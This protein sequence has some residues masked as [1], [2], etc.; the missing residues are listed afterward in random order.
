MI[1]INPFFNDWDTPYCIPPFEEI[2]PEHFEPAFLEAFE[3]HNADI[4]R[5]VEDKSPPTFENTILQLEQAGRMLE[6]VTAVYNCFNQTRATDEQR[7]VEAKIAPLIADH[8]NNIYQNYDLYLRVK[9]VNEKR[10]SL[11]IQKQ[12]ALDVYLQLFKNSGVDLAQ[13]Q[14]TKISEIDSTLSELYAQFNQNVANDEENF[15]LPLYNFN[16]QA[17]LGKEYLANA[18]K[19]GRLRGYDFPVATLGIGSTAY[20]LKHAK[21]RHLRKL[22]Y[23][24]SKARGSGANKN[25]NSG[26]M[27]KIAELRAQRA[28]VLGYETYAEYAHAQNMAENPQMVNDMLSSVWNMALPQMEIDYEGIFELA[29]KDGIRKLEP[30]DWDYYATQYAE[31]VFSLDHALISEYLVLDNCLDAAFYAAK[32]L[33]GL[34]F[35]E[36]TDWP[37]FHSDARVWDVTDAEGRHVAVFMA[38]LFARKGK[39]D[40]AAMDQCRPQNS[41]VEDETGTPIVYIYCNFT[42]PEHGKPALLSLGEYSW[43]LF[44]EMGHAL[45]GMLS[46]VDYPC[47]AGTR[48]KMD[49]VEIPSILFETFSLHPEVMGH[50][51]KHHRT[52]EMMPEEMQRTIRDAT[53]FN[54]GF[55]MAEVVLAAFLDLRL[56]SQQAGKTEALA[57]IQAQ[58]MKDMNVPEYLRPRHEFG[59]FRH[60][61]S[62]D[63]AGNYYSYVW[64]YY[65]VAN[66]MNELSKSGNIIDLPVVKKL[67][68]LLYSAGNSE[69]PNAL[70]REIMGGEN[71]EHGAMRTI[72]G[73][74]N[75]PSRSGQSGRGIISQPLVVRLH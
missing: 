52:N 33:F 16:D 57:D 23:E 61:M 44:H 5:I 31:K 65:V 69:N 75:R 53:K 67:K 3:K 42:K 29:L 17:G 19:E 71:L 22:V 72:F 70:I 12:R 39:S 41:L 51:V 32:R 58:V 27:K 14:K 62:V 24:A 63:Y 48:V 47:L 2:F 21:C 68:E 46:M 54:K 11:D 6:R 37:V 10:E 15:C 38:D 28:K 60:L 36:K 13:E 56:H 18:L 66:I 43:I 35:S 7:Q 8:I 1:N 4:L 45:H 25:N 34:N 64:A 74:A 40:G 9:G 49:L 59:H 20:F 55:E 30:W 73:D 50:A 26:I